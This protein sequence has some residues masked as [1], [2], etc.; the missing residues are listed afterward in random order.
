MGC[1]RRGKGR[2]GQWSVIKGIAEFEKANENPD[3]VVYVVSRS[4]KNSGSPVAASASKE[5]ERYFVL[6]Y[7]CCFFFFAVKIDS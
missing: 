7:C 4:C 6:F 1:G 2:V 3:I 5:K